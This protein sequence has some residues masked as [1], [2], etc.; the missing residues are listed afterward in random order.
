MKTYR[1]AMAQQFGGRIPKAPFSYTEFDQANAMNLGKKIIG[2]KKMAVLAVPGLLV[3]GWL[4][5]AYFGSPY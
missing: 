3:V 1:Q 4:G 5:S 2:Q